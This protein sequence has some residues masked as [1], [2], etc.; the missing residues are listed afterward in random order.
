MSEFSQEVSRINR[1]VS[2]FATA[3]LALSKSATLVHPLTD[4]QATTSQYRRPPARVHQRAR[5]QYQYSSAQSSS[6][7]AYSGKGPPPGPGGIRQ[8]N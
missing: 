3:H 2:A 5:P 1:Q 6:H 4:H 7:L 8:W